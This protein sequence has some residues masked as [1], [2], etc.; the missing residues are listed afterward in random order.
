MYHSVPQIR[1]PF[2]NLSLSTKCGGG[3]GGGLILAMSNFYN[4]TLC[5][6]KNFHAKTGNEDVFV[7]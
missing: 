6:I 5:S 4:F 2:C 3:G 1:P 7:G